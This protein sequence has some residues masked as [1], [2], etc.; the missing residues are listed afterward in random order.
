MEVLD[1]MNVPGESC[2]SASGA[3]LL[4]LDRGSINC[5]LISFS[6]NREISQALCSQLW[7]P[8]LLCCFQP[9]SG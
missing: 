1:R 2:T 9:A 3:G 4:A 5:V 8:T 6:D 7:V